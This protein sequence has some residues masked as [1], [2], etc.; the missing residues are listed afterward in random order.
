MHH[1][2]VLR[3]I[4]GDRF[5]IGEIYGKYLAAVGLLVLRTKQG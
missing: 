3:N 5:K 2:V 4:F 1:P